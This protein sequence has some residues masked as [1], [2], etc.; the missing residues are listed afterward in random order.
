MG[1]D[2]IW[3]KKSNEEAV[4]W[5]YEQISKYKKENK[6]VDI[7]QIV[8]D[9]LHENLATDVTSSGKY[10]LTNLVKN[11]SLI[12]LYFL[13]GVG[14]DNMTCVLILFDQSKL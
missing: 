10:Y 13:G 1:C 7:K 12:D 4:H 11:I 8:A 5:I 6:E 9:L 3:E 14:C 2:G